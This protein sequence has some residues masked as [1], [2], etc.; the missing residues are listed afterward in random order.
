MDQKQSSKNLIELLKMYDQLY[1]NEGTSPITD[2]EY[3]NLWKT[4]KE[5]YPND[6]YFSQVGHSIESKFE[7]IKL[8]FTMGGLDMVNPEDVHNWLAKE[9]DDTVASEKLDGNSIGCTWVDYKLIFAGSRGN[10]I[11]GQNLLNKIKYSLHNIPVNYKVSL[12]GEVLLKGDIFKDL[13]FKNRRNAVTGILRRDKISPEILKRLSVIFYE[14][15]EAPPELNLKTEL[16]RIKFIKDTL[17]LEVTRFVYIPKEVKGNLATKMLVESLEFMKESANYDI[18]GLVLTRNNSLRENTMHPLNKVKFKVNQFAIL[19]KVIGIEWNVTRLGY[20]KPVVLIEPTEIMGT[21]VSRCS[22]FNYN[23]IHSNSIGKDSEIGVVRSGDVIPFITEIYK[24]TKAN[25]P[26]RCASC[27]SLL[28]ITVDDKGNDVDLLCVNKNCNQKMLYQ[29][30]H[31]F[32]TMGVDGLSDKTFE[33][34]GVTSIPGIYGLTKKNLSKIPGFADKKVE[35]FLSEIKKT[36]L[37]KP[38]RLL[39]AF[40]I[41]LIGRTLSKQLCSKYTIDELFN[42]S[43]PD[44]I[45][46]GPI[47]SQTLIDNLKDYK[48]LYDFL[49]SIGLQFEVEDKSLKTLIG[50]IFA[51]TGEGP[52]KRSEIQKL[53]ESKGGEVKGIGKGTKY[54]VTNDPDSNSNKMKDA[55]KHN[56][57]VISYDVLFAMLNNS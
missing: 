28:E 1:F 25:I 23:F 47:T 45:G 16:D 27:N 17:G 37:T 34:I 24:S 7:E 9:N 30:S 4:A 8:P 2:T 14:V 36:L 33:N 52:M 20:I 56:I 32:I 21:T 38:E 13:D 12:R 54:L 53:I 50:M 18:D 3:D 6:P 46:L 41:P 35:N 39:A 19:C 11:K 49:K 15:V 55:K 31:F 51:L 10:G 40:G 57:E 42:M 22:G 26:D 44:K 43:D 29:V 48:E 5:K